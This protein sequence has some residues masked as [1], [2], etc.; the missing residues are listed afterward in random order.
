[1]ECYKEFFIHNF[2]LK[3]SSL[4]DELI[5]SS[6]IS[7]Y[8]VIRIEQGI[9]LFLEDHLNRLFYSADLSNLSIN[10][11]YCDIETLI[12]E[13]IK[14]N[15]T[16]E[17]KI[18][19]VIRFDKTNGHKEKDFLIYF[20]PHYFPTAE[21]YNLG[22]KIGICQA[23]R[24]NPNAKILNTDARNKADKTIAE[25]KLFEVLLI[26]NEGFI[27]E[28]SRSNIFFIKD[29]KII[30]PPEKDVLNGV[31]RKNVVKICKQNKIELIEE[32]INFSDIQKMDSIFL[33]GTSLKVLPVRS[34]E[35][36]EYNTQNRLLIYLKDLYEKLIL[37]YISSKK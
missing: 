35:G 21:E 31:T 1:M 33:T 2:K 3:Q 25:E 24:T 22:V 26:N 23:I 4:F 7:I 28:G 5:L 10:E 14:K 13:L 17:G 36:I 34:L 30:T 16:E 8:E 15:K 20:T 12:S 6:G 19:L 32:K 27:S 9:P 37:E 18:K 29:N 11:S